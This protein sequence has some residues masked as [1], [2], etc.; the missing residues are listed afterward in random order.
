LRRITSEIP[1]A[2]S[3]FECHRFLSTSACSRSAEIVGASRRSGQVRLTRKR[4]QETQARETR[5]R[6]AERPLGNAEAEW[7]LS[8]RH[9]AWSMQ[10]PCARWAK[11]VR[12]ASE[13]LAPHELKSSSSKSAAAPLRLRE[14]KQ[15]PA[16]ARARRHIARAEGTLNSGKLVGTRR[17]TPS[18]VES[19]FRQ[20]SDVAL[21]PA[22]LS[23]GPVASHSSLETQCESRHCLGNSRLPEG[24]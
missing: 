14:Q 12:L 10:R 3:Y 6:A 21:P 13:A 18:A 24:G 19:A 16:A 2:P 23:R 4:T 8:A 1:H 22:P 11:S 9:S 17:S 20:R 15:A 7:A 5:A